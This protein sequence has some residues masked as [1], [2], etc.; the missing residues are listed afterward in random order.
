MG[1]NIYNY[2]Y[3]LKT[4]CINI[5]RHIYVFIIYSDVYLHKKNFIDFKNDIY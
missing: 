2:I 4:I 1:K 5:Y 3:I